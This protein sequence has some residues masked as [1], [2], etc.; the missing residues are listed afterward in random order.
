M[1]RAGV[2]LA[3]VEEVAVKVRVAAARAV[4]AWAV[5]ARALG[6]QAA[7]AKGAVLVGAEVAA[8]AMAVQVAERGA[9]ATAAVA[10]EG[11]GAVSV[12]Q[13]A[14]CN[15]ADHNLRLRSRNVARGRSVATVLP[16][17]GAR[18]TIRI[19]SPRTVGAVRTESK[20]RVWSTIITGTSQPEEA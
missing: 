10:M 15:A 14:A 9:E 1:A 13:T 11:Q 18:A 7:V 2:A 5:A 4:V 16:W 19:P 8:G 12:V 20:G 6:A 17:A 3:K